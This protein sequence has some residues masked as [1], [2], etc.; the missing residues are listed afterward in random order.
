ML[1]KIRWMVLTLATLM[2]VIGASGCAVP[3]SAGP[4]GDSTSGSS[5]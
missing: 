1:E 4:S 5:G 3:G 2:A